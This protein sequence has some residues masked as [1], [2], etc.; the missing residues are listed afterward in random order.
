MSNFNERLTPNAV[1]FW[2]VLVEIGM[3]VDDPVDEDATIECTIKDLMEHGI[4]Y[5]TS[6]IESKWIHVLPYGYPIPTLDRDGE[7]EKVHRTLEK[8]H[9]YSRGRFG[10]WRYEVANQDHSFTMGTDVIDRILYGKEETVKFIRCASV[11][12]FK[13]CSIKMDACKSDEEHDY[14]GHI[15]WQLLTSIGSQ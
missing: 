11:A 14:G 13:W 4:I 9:I 7:L 15:F 2:S 10:S 5:P 12:G 3:A 1:L 6:K 8:E